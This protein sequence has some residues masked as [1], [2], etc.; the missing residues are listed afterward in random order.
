M[1]CIGFGK[2]LLKEKWFEKRRYVVD[3]P[4]VYTSRVQ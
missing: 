4:C 2:L 1:V 3:F